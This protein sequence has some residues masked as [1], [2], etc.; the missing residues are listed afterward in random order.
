MWPPSAALEGGARWLAVRAAD[1]ADSGRDEVER[2]ARNGTPRPPHSTPP[3][4]E[5]LRP[6]ASE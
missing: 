6:S 1:E 2:E 5:I 4:E 3:D